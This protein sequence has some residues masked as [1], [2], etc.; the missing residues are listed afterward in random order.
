MIHTRKKQK[1]STGV[2]IGY[3]AWMAALAVLLIA[4]GCYYAVL[5]NEQ[6]AVRRSIEKLHLQTSTCNLAAK[7]YRAKTSSRINRVA[8]RDRLSQ[9]HSEL[10]NIVASQIEVAEQQPKRAVAGN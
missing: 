4:G 2:S 5:K 3:L 1:F 6:I 8:I 7:Q 10:Q 9:E